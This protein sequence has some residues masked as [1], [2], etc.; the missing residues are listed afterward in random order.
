MPPRIGH[1]AATQVLRIAQE[2]LQNVEKHAQA[3][4]VAVGSVADDR[5]LRV[6]VR[7]DGIGFAPGA[8]ASG[9]GNGFGLLSLRERAR[10]AGGTLTVESAPGQGTQVSVAIP[11]K[12]EGPGEGAALPEAHPHTANPT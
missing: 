9:N 6:W 4:A 7:D 12:Q 2:A 10:L 8:P 3:S 5:Q 1:A 11:L